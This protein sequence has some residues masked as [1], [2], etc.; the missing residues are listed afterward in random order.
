MKKMKKLA[1]SCIFAA[2]ALLTISC[3]QDDDSGND[4]A[5]DF[6]SYPANYS[7]I[8]SNKSN[9]NLV[10][11]KNQ[12]KD[13]NLIGAV[14]S[15]KENHY[16]K[17]NPDLF[18]TTG[19]FRLIAITEEDYKKNKDSL[20]S[21]TNNPFTRIFAFYNA[22][23]SNDTVYE[24]SGNLGGQYKLTIQNTT[25]YNVELRKNGINGEII[26]YAPARQADTILNLNEG[27]YTLFPVFIKYNKLKDSIFKVIPTYPETSLS[28]ELRGFPKFDYFALGDGETEEQDHQFY[29]SQFK[30][31]DYSFVSGSAYLRIDNQSSTSVRLVKGSNVVKTNTGSGETIKS[32]ASYIY[33]IN[34]T[35][36]P[37][38]SYP[39]EQEF[40]NT[41]K[42]G[43]GITQGLTL[44]KFKFESDKIY[45]LKVTGKDAANLQIGN[46]EFLEDVDWDKLSDD[47]N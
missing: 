17:R 31:D 19:S 32:G 33:E 16:V 6:N 41:Y 3:N 24:I 28:E 35:Q 29:A 47:S 38:G 25:S 34:F 7:I 40:E 21:L 20:Q 36:N 2:C 12:L 46:I 9:E 11:F 5:L 45:K 42:I 1:L 10:L 4:S 39:K 18:G 26:G 22:Q 13:T 37:N 43:V 14:E 27:T 23:G 44:P 30:N 8:V 15:Y